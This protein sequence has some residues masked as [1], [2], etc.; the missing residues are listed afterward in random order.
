MK[1]IY[2]DEMVAKAPRFA[3]QLVLIKGNGFCPSFTNCGSSLQGA[4]FANSMEGGGSCGGSNRAGL[5]EQL[6]AL[7]RKREGELASYTSRL[8]RG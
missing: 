1:T 5:V 4:P 7:L 3:Q 2:I 6:E 8:V